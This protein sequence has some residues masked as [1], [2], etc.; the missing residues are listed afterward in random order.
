MTIHAVASTAIP[1][2]AERIF[3][4]QKPQLQRPPAEFFSLEGKE[5][6]WYPLRLCC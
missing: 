6:E 1:M 4:M 3:G 2:L 5:K